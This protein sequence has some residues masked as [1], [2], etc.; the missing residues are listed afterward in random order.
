[1]QGIQKELQEARQQR[2]L[3]EQEAAQLS[4]INSRL[5]ADNAELAQ[6]TGALRAENEELIQRT[7]RLLDRQQLLEQC[8]E[9]LKLENGNLIQQVGRS[10][11]GA[12]RPHPPAAAA[13]R[14]VQPAARPQ[15]A[16]CTP[17]Q[18]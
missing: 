16:R 13:G 8:A 6:A 9:S 1:M 10:R 4:S 12:Q 2:E 14:A 11:G 5:Q 18:C 17:T 7:D 3:T 15:P